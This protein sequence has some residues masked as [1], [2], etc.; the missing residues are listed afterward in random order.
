MAAESHG[1]TVRLFTLTYILTAQTGKVSMEKNP[2]NDTKQKEVEDAEKETALK[3]VREENKKTQHTSLTFTGKS[4]EY[5]KIWVV[6]VFLTI[7][8]IG[9]YS[10]WAKVR[11][12]RYF[13]RST[14]L[15]DSSFDYL[16]EP[17]KILKGRLIVFG[18]LI[19]IIV[20][21]YFYP[22]LLLILA[23]PA[24]LLFPWLVV[25]A[26][27]F[28]ARNSSYRNIR[29][30]FLGTYGEAVK[31]LILQ[32]LITI[33]TLGFGYPYQRYRRT[34]FVFDNGIFGKTP[35]RLKLKNSGGFYS[36]YLWQPIGVGILVGL[37]NVAILAIGGAFLPA[38]AYPMFE[39]FISFLASL[40]IIAFLRAA[41]TN[42][43][44]SNVVLGSYPPGVSVYFG[45]TLSAPKMIWIYLSNALAIVFSLGLLVPW[46][47]VR[48]VR[49]R[50]SNLN[51][52]ISGGLDSFVASEQ[53]KVE[54]VGEEI[55]DFFDFDLGL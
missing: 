12:K 36:V 39:S 22:F 16:A 35:F 13:Y 20:A 51:V 52:S 33:L 54:A 27:N 3:E 24:I 4:G 2:D 55:T 43:V 49:Y 1:V 50:L 25:K 21:G 8:T 46:A 26:L 53:E 29:F 19:L 17:K 15:L 34:K 11:K 23:I 45:S 7:L 28:K 42:L 47:S 9:I 44:W 30:D 31:V 14:F 41:G 18:T 37:A 38:A 6:N 10:A 48:T 32:M 40:A 5:F